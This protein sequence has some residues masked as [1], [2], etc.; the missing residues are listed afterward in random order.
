MAETTAGKIARDATGKVQEIG[1][2]AKTSAEQAAGQLSDVAGELYDHAKSAAQETAD[3]VKRHAAP[4]D[5]IFRKTIEESP[6]TAVFLALAFGWL[7]GHI[8]ATRR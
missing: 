6:Y 7:V 2:K 3:V 4:M 5:D 8:G 1:A